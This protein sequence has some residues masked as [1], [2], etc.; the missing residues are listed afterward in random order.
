[1]VVKVVIVKIGFLASTPLIEAL[2]DERAVRKDITIRGVATGCRMEREDTLDVVKNA[3]NYAPNLLVIISPNINQPGPKEAI[4]TLAESLTPMIVISDK[5]S[6]KFVE[7]LRD[8][9][10]GYMIINGDSMIGARRDFLDPVEMAIFNSDVIKVLA[11][12]G[13]FRL[14]QIEVDK[15]IN[16]LK[17]ELIVE[18][19]QMVVDGEMA[20][21]YAEFSNPYAQSKALASYRM[22]EAVGRLSVEGCYLIKERDKYLPIIAAAH[23]LMRKAAMLADEARELEKNNDTVV[24]KVHFDDGTIH[25]KTGLFEVFT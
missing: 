3:L 11:V 25:S 8:K 18:L 15:V 20:I 1:M 12:T 13:A 7:K 5:S 17:N 4:E 14:I 2:L 24:R 21:K 23:E 22:A 9:S 16:R 19:P 6:E 10:L